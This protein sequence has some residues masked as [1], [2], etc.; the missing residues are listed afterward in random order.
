[1]V[2]QA[3]LHKHFK[4]GQN[5]VSPQTERTG[6]DKTV[7]RWNQRMDKTV[8]RPQTMLENGQNPLLDTVFQ[9]PGANSCIHLKGNDLDEYLVPK[10]NKILPEFLR[11]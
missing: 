9:S 7:F 10:M 2:I 8:F 3:C 4:N 6:T 1:M 11:K 5:H